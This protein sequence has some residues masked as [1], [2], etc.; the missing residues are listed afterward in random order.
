MQAVL[1]RKQKYLT[2]SHPL[3]PASFHKYLSGGM[4]AGLNEIAYLKWRTAEGVV[5]ALSPE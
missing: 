2:E 1:E 4:T 3:K 5:K